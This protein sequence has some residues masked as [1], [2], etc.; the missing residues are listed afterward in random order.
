MKTSE[1][2]ENV[3]GTTP[4]LEVITHQIEMFHGGCGGKQCSRSGLKKCGSSD[5]ARE[6]LQEEM[7]LCSLADSRKL[8]SQITGVSP[9][10]N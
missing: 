4:K 6:H 5:T 8:L 10:V 9:L 2:T 3:F 7:F 1:G